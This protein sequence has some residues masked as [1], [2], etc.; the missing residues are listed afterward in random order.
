MS[1]KK[2]QRGLTLV[3]VI[4]VVAII[5]VLAAVAVPNYIS[6]LPTFR[7]RGAAR[8][9]M[10]AMQTARMNAVKEAKDWAVHYNVAGD[11]YALCY[12][13]D[14]GTADW[15]DFTNELAADADGDGINNIVC[16]G[17]LSLPSYKSGVEIGSGGSGVADPVSFTDD[18]AVF[19][20]KGFLD[21][22]TNGYAYIENE[23]NDS[24]RIGAFTSGV[25]KMEKWSGS[26]WAM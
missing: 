16:Q 17:Y 22:A 23:N 9:L 14:A 4:V 19:N 13:D 1:D 10:A 7:L 12:E 3:E 21:G 5:G 2:W 6:A 15:T 8:D 11:R 24:F 25:V 20:A 18:L 26:G